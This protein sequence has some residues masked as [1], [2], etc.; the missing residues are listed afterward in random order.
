MNL[1]TEKRVTKYCKFNCKIQNM[2][3]TN[4]AYIFVIIFY[5]YN[6]NFILKRVIS[7]YSIF[8]DFDS[9]FVELKNSLGRTLILD[10]WNSNRL[11]KLS[12]KYSSVGNY[13]DAV[14]NLIK[15]Y[16]LK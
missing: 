16:W 10:L 9:I 5:I 4:Q 2:Y 1:K 11:E 7:K 13:S 14:I 6:S 8:W 12:S 15:S 3:I